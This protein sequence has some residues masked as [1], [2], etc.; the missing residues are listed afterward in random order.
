MSWFGK[1]VNYGEYYSS[2]W[3]CGKAIDKIQCNV[4]PGYVLEQSGGVSIMVFIQAQIE[5][6]AA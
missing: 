2:A 5:Q 4:R 3:G 1:P 6:A